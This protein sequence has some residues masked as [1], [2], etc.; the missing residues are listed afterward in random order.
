LRGI[1]ALMK[2]EAEQVPAVEL[3][4]IDGKDSAINFFRL[5]QSPG[6]MQRQSLRQQRGQ[7][8]WFHGS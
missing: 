6:L 4:R 7:L 3:I 5:G 2:Y 1:A 8:G